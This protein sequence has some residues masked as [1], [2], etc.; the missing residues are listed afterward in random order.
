[1]GGNGG[2]EGR[3]ETGVGKGVV[4]V[5]VQLWR[6]GVKYEGERL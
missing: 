3:R 6:G 2:S 5:W 1:V 4:D